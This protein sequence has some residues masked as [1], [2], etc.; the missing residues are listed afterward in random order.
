M[1]HKGYVYYDSTEKCWYARTTVTYNSKRRNLKRRANSKL[2]AKHALKTILSQVDAEGGKFA[3]AARMTFDDL[4]DHY[5][6]RYLKPAE[7]AE[8]RKI[9]GLRDVERPLECLARFASTSVS[10]S[11]EKSPMG[12]YTITEPFA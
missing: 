12:M 11:C 5:Q 6:S 10:K 1:Q 2:E 8:G 9:A 3:D 4:A 7:Y